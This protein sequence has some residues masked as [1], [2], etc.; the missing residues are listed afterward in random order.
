MLTKKGAQTVTI[1]IYQKPAHDSG[2]RTNMLIK[3]YK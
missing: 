3:I 2:L 1:Y